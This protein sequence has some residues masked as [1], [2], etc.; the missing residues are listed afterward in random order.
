MQK[1][2]RYI[3][4]CHSSYIWVVTDDPSPSTPGFSVCPVTGPLCNMSCGKETH[5]LQKI[6]IK[7]RRRIREG[8]V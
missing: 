8:G 7:E 2:S 4:K 1:G 3:K 6:K 5:L